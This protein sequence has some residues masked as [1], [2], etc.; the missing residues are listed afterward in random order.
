MEDVKRQG[1]ATETTELCEKCG[2]TADAE[3]G[4]VRQ[5]LL[6]QQL[7]P[8]TKPVTIA[9]G[10]A[11][12]GSESG[13]EEGAAA[14][15][16]FPM[17]VKAMDRRDDGVE[18][19]SSVEDAKLASLKP[20]RCSQAAAGQATNWCIVERCQLRLSPRRTSAAKP[21]LNGARSAGRRGRRGVLR[22][23]RTDDGT[24][25]TDRGVHSW[26]ARAIATIRRARRSAS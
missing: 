3:V 23:L 18:Q 1:V 21:D 13:C 16:H 8:S 9:A 7:Q 20:W 4:Q 26:R 10:C 17:I 15:F 24:E 2:S 19:Q 25:A 22:Q 5:L 6:L 12:E 14:R 11:E